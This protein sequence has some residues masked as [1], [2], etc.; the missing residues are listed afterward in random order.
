MDDRGSFKEVQLI[1]CNSL[2]KQTPNPGSRE[3]ML[4][5]ES[6]RQGPLMFLWR[7]LPSLLGGPHRRSELLQRNWRRKAKQCNQGHTDSKDAWYSL[8]CRIPPSEL[9]K[10]SCCPQL[11]PRHSSSS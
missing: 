6:F 9:T 10:S 2:H 1:P 8:G 3:R 11:G 4:K 5:A 7:W